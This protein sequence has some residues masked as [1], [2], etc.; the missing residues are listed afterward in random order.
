MMSAVRADIRGFP[1][2]LVGTDGSVWTLWKRSG[3]GYG[4]GTFFFIGD[5]PRMM[6]TTIDKGGYA[7]VILRRNNDGRSYRRAVHKLVLTAFVGPCPRGKQC[8]HL[9]G[10]PSNNIK[11]NLKWGTAKENADDRA[12]HGNTRTGT[13]NPRARFSEQDVKEM[14]RLAADGVAPKAIGKKFNARYTTV[15][16]IVSGRTW[17]SLK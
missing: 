15:S 14:R 10:N 16:N 12:L 17:K 7:H 4:G 3:Y 5:T 11:S 9:D 13:T 6:R 8:R 1:G 2:Y